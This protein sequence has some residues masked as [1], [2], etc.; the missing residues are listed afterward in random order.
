MILPR[1]FGTAWVYRKTEV[2]ISL[3]YHSEW[4]QQ[5]RMP[6]MLYEPV[7]CTHVIQCGC[8]WLQRSPSFFSTLQLS[9]SPHEYVFGPRR[10]LTKFNSQ[11]TEDASSVRA[12]TVPGCES[13]QNEHSDRRKRVILPRTEAK[14]CVFLATNNMI[15][16]ELAPPEDSYKRLDE[17]D[18]LS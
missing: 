5:P 18:L 11:L 16:P 15:H 8:A 2:E 17:S 14:I 10:S 3:G 4:K 7:P 6:S 1:A 12:A 13:G 9:K